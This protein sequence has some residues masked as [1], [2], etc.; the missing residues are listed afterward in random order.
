MMK[1]ARY[2]GRISREGMRRSAILLLS[3]MA[4]ALVM[5]SGVAWAAASILMALGSKH[6]DG[7]IPYPR[8]HKRERPRDE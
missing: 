3:K 7:V 1:V 5:G 4:T 2:T 8:P 6:R